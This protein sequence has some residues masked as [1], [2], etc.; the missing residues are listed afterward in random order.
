MSAVAEPV[1]FQSLTVEQWADLDDDVEGELVDGELVEEEMATPLHEM[2][3]ARLLKLLSFWVDPLGGFV[4]GAEVKLAL[5]KRR[6]RKADVIVYLPGQPLP[7]RNVSA[8]RRPPSI[9]VEVISSSPRDLRRDIVTRGRTTL[10]SACPITGS[11]IPS[12][13]P[14]RCSSSAPAGTTGLF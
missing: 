6:G 13:A 10:R 4:F 1:P 14:S 8:T 9:A 7:G 12:R 11:S 5:S 2:S 3:A